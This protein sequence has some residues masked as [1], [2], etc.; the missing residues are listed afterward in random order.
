[1]QTTKV[2][3]PDSLQTPPRSKPSDRSSTSDRRTKGR[4]SEKKSQMKT[5]SSKTET[6][7]PIVYDD[8]SSSRSKGTT[9]S[10]LNLKGPPASVCSQRRDDRLIESKRESSSKN[11]Q[12]R[13]M[14]RHDSQRS[15]LSEIP[16]D[17]SIIEGR[18]SQH[19]GI[20]DSDVL[21]VDA[22]L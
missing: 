14:S 18:L 13:K 17:G 4:S 2:A 15:V 10:R 7:D 1:M 6:V 16:L 11:P 5:R 22:F 12:S 9:P 21:S 20:T 3:P 8:R 19:C